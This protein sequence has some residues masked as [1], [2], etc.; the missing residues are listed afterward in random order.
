MDLRLAEFLAATSDDGEAYL[1]V[2]ELGESLQRARDKAVRAL[3]GA[4]RA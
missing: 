4:R 2:D 3:P 1:H